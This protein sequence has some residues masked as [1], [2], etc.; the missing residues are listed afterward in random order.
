MCNWCSV[1]L[2]PTAPGEGEVR[3][4]GGSGPHEGRVEV[5]RNGHWGTACDDGWDLQDA[6]VVCRQLG[7]GTAG[8]ALRFAAYG[9]GSGP[10][11]YGNVDC[12]GSEAN[13]DQCAHNGLGVHNCVHSE[14]AGAIC[15]SE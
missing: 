3:L 9:E 12:S 5:L 11:W 7:Y 8:A 14:D 15:A 2:L 1:L 13:L 6:T 10:I 4:V